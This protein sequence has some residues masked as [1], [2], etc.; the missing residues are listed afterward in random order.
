MLA[1]RIVTT[2][3]SQT[4][5]K[6]LKVSPRVSWHMGAKFRTSL[7]NSQQNMWLTGTVEIDETY[8]GGKGT[9]DLRL[10]TAIWQWE[11]EQDKINGVSDYKRRKSGDLYKR[12]RK[13]G[14][15]NGQKGIK[16]EPNS[17]RTKR[18]AYGNQIAVLGMKQRNGPCVY[19]VLGRG[20]SSVSLDEVLPFLQKFI[21]PTAMVIS[22]DASH[23]RK[24]KEHFPNHQVIKKKTG[25]CYFDQA[26]GK[27]GRTYCAFV[28]IDGERRMIS[29]NGLED[30]WGHFKG[31]T[32][33]EY[34]FY[35]AEH[36]QGYLAEFAFRDKKGFE[37]DKF[38]SMFNE[39]LL[40]MC[41]SKITVNDVRK[42]TW[43]YDENHTS[44]RKRR[45]ILRCIA[46]LLSVICEK[47][48]YLKQLLFSRS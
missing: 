6:D 14:T 34:S 8:I 26:T 1:D 11:R 5:F 38:Q 43:E 47:L 2:S 40:N 31:E 39:L 46:K 18:Q 12:G 25:K 20:K 22:D 16:K 15:K 19:V 48:I 44:K 32:R 29:V 28:E 13:P 27:P 36:M 17:W 7:M 10:A 23:Y 35:T 37:F 45:R 30:R 21:D 3:N 24:L 42:F 41:A 33:G 9:S 4:T